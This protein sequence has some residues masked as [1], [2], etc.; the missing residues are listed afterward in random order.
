M[1]RA[2]ERVCVTEIAMTHLKAAAPHLTAC[3][4]EWG[5]PLYSGPEPATRW[6]LRITVTAWAGPAGA[7]LRV[8]S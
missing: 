4:R 1:D 2:P 5:P 3:N 8:S 7:G 6:P